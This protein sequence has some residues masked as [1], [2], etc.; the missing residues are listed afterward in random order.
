MTRPEKGE[1]RH[2]D[3]LRISRQDSNLQP[4]VSNTGALSIE[5]RKHVYLYLVSRF[6]CSMGALYNRG[7]CCA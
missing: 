7:G 3:A 2:V 6:A 1:G 4:P 5:L